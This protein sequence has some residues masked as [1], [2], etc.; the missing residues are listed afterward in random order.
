MSFV[1]DTA[2]ANFHN[3]SYLCITPSPSP[4][5]GNSVVISNQAENVLQISN[6][7]NPVFSVEVYNI[8]GQLQFRSN[9]E[10]TISLSDL[11]PGIYAVSVIQGEQKTTKMTFVK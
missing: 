9:N 5:R 1:F 11:E 3:N 4:F 8:M 6:V 10:S 2:Y 7:E